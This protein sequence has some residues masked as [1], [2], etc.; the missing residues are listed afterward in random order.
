VLV[1]ACARRFDGAC[2]LVRPLADGATSNRDGRGQPA[3][4]DDRILKVSP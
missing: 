2:R 4:E 3:A 1:S